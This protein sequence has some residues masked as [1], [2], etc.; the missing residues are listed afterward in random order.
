MAR[1]ECEKRGQMCRWSESSVAK[2]VD[3]VKA[4]WPNVSIEV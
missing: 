4:M 2:C 1:C 3:G